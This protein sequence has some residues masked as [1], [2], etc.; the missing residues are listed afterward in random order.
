MAIRRSGAVVRTSTGRPPSLAATFGAA[1]P[2]VIRATI[3]PGPSSRLSS[4]S[5]T[6]PWAIRAPGSKLTAVSQECSA[7]SLSRKA[8]APATSTTVSSP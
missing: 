3:H 2:R 5:G 4:S 7:C 6:D 8:A 1:P